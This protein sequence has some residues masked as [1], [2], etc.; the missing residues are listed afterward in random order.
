MER[1]T[2]KP[3]VQ[4][5]LHCLTGCFIGDMVGM[6]LGM[7][8]GWSNLATLTVSII[9]A[10]AFGYALTIWSMTKSGMTVGTAM[11]TAFI[12]DTLSIATMEIVA[13]VIVS[14]SGVM[15]KGFLLSLGVTVL[16]FVVA[17]FVTVPVN[18]FLMS[19]GMGHAHYSHESHS[20]H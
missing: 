3:A 19:R 2:W 14:S 5:T 13:N 7:S 6:V 15:D 8:L 10:F 17:F 16:A 20:H 11:R 9:L 1:I 4:A 12:A 18:R